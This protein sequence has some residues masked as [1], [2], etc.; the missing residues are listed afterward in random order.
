MELKG[1][2]HLLFVEHNDVGRPSW[3]IIY[4]SNDVTKLL[5]KCYVHTQCNL[6]VT[7]SKFIIMPQ[8]SAT[9]VPN[10]NIYFTPL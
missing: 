5:Q 8:F 7:R 2:Q 1:T 10:T 4:V 9:T 3:P 6:V